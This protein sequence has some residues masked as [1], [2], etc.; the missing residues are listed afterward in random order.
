MK[1][2][3][4]GGDVMNLEFHPKFNST[5][6]GLTAASGRKSSMLELKCLKEGNTSF[7]DLLTQTK[8]GKKPPAV[9]KPIASAGNLQNSLPNEQIS[10]KENKD[11]NSDPLKEGLLLEP[12]QAMN[13]PTVEENNRDKFNPLVQNGG[14]SYFQSPPQLYSTPI[15]GNEENV[16]LVTGNND[17]N[18]GIGDVSPLENQLV[19]NT[20]NSSQIGQLS[21]GQKET[22]QNFKNFVSLGDNNLELTKP[23]ASLE[24]IVGKVNSTIP[25]NTGTEQK[26]IGPEEPVEVTQTENPQ[27]SLEPILGKADMT[28]PENIGTEQKA[29]G[30]DGPLEVTQTEKSLKSPE[31]ILGKVDLTIPEKVE[32][33]QK[34]LGSEG[35]IDIKETGKSLKSTDPILGEADEFLIENT[36][37]EK[38][39]IGTEDQNGSIQRGMDE[40]P[41]INILPTKNTVIQTVDNVAVSAQIE[42]QIILQLDKNKPI[43]F[44]MKLNPENLGEIDV[45]LKF[46][47]GKLIIDITAFSKDTQA[48]LM[49]QIDKL[50]KGLALQNVQ[51]ES[52]HLNNQTQ[53][54]NGSDSKALMMNMGMDFTQSQKH[55]LSRES[56]RNQNNLTKNGNPDDDQE[57][58]VG[59]SGN[60]QSRP[61]RYHK[62]NVLI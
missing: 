26:A 49:G 15:T 5:N 2:S 45:Q 8:N 22:S 25:D 51:V 23:Q 43:T 18:I 29:I 37:T 9:E 40:I 27:A 52:V 50:I 13:T 1:N 16:Q 53:N 24:P 36:G 41:L 12:F 60:E 56:F 14:M 62:I 19:E 3:I 48:L 30:P 4:E 17:L 46:D 57:L 28:I 20:T 34:T 58:V 54:S 31:P 61:P 35:K 33:R 59:I 10:G 11:K 47:Q 42:Q 21:E 32:T 6:D 44:Q 7:K 39:T 55:A 38:K